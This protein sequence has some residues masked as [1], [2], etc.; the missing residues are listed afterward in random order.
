MNDHTEEVLGFNQDVQKAIVGWMLSNNAFFL[1]CKQYIDYSYFQEPIVAEIV[2][3]AY[4]I[5][6]ETNRHPQIL[7]V[8]ARI[9]EVHYSIQEAK[10]R[11][12]VIDECIRFKD[13]VTLQYLVSQM[14]SW[15]RLILLR[16]AFRQGHAFYI[17]KKYEDAKRWLQKL[18]E[19]INTTSFDYDDKVALGRGIDHFITRLEDRNYACTIGHE[20]FDELLLS[21]SAIPKSE[22]G[23][24]I[25]DQYNRSKKGFYDIK[26][27]TRGGLLPG[28]ATILMGP[29][30]SGKTSAVVSVIK[31]N[32]ELGKKVLLIVCE[33]TEEEILDKLYSNIT[34]YTVQELSMVSSSAASSSEN[35]SLK[36]KVYAALRA[37]DALMLDNLVYIHHV[38]S[39]KMYVED[40]LDRLM[41]AQQ[42]MKV[43][44]YNKRHAIKQE[45]LK[46]G[47][48][49]DQLE[50]KLNLQDQLNRGFDLVVIDY[51]AKL[52]SRNMIGRKIST[53]DEQQYVYD[54]IIVTAQAEKFH[55]L[56][57]VQTNREGYK[58]ALGLGS[59]ERMLGQGDVANSY[60]IAQ[61]ASNFIT[62]NR[63]L[64]DKKKNIIKFYIDKSRSAATG[65]VFV[66]KTDFSCSRTHDI[67]L[68]YYIIG[69]GMHIN[70]EEIDRGLGIQPSNITKKPDLIP[71]KGVL[72]EQLFAAQDNEGE[73]AETINHNC[74]H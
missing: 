13:T 30:N 56:L 34:G 9:N 60:G 28:A 41:L 55:A 26:K 65:A 3:L 49:N 6:D 54:Q 62:I 72:N 47:V 58:V 33:M 70:N 14:T 1:R 66:S 16:R 64:E 48:W 38:K 51:P 52:K 20:A 4:E 59:E 25:E 39:G 36:D 8:K 68:D 40:V 32:L 42:E 46:R 61:V 21:G 5:Y 31:A 2:K 27:R 22:W 17:Q 43:K 7:D 15:K 35:G 45:A 29:S 37:A 18:I 24:E 53:H 44:Q 12:F 19:E 73:D 57:P 63:S 74:E 71:P 10:A 50:Q 11:W 69:P 67:R 23:E